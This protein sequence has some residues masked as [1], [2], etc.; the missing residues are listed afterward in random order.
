M[1]KLPV[2]DALMQSLYF[3]DYGDAKLMLAGSRLLNSA[4][5]SRLMPQREWLIKQLLEHQRQLEA[6]WGE[7]D[8]M[9][10]LLNRL[11]ATWE[12]GVDEEPRLLVRID[13]ARALA[14]QLYD[15]I[16]TKIA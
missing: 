12:E 8:V 4:F 11:T 5:M 6:L 1:A 3:L 13:A 10:G 7:W 2:R 15:E 9:Y 14:D 16:T